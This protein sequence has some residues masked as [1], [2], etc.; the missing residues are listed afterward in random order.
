MLETSTGAPFWIH[1]AMREKVGGDV[2]KIPFLMWH[3]HYGIPS[4]KK[5]A[6]CLRGGKRE[7][8]IFC[9]PGKLWFVC[10]K[11]RLHSTPSSAHEM[12]SLN[13]F[14][15]RN[16]WIKVSPNFHAVTLISGTLA[17][18]AVAVEFK[19]SW[20]SLLEEC[21]WCAHE[22]GIIE[23]GFVSGNKCRSGK[24]DWENYW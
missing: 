20:L 9:G 21:G 2:G 5:D 11:T 19:V 15:A 17:I 23:S 18:V 10:R 16:G 8:P 1:P 4:P 6:W 3:W 24:L 14:R 22:R 7:I 12:V 13:D